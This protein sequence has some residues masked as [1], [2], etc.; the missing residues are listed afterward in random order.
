MLTEII[1]DYPTVGEITTYLLEMSKAQAAE[2]PAAQPQQQLQYAQQ[3]Q[4]APVQQQQAMMQPVMQP[5]TPEA[6]LQAAT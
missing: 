4:L 6:A 1:F 2:A 5:Q 3:Q